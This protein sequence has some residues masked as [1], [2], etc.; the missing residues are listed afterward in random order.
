M[1][2]QVSKAQV[3]AV[4]LF[5]VVCVSVGEAL[6]SVGM[7]QVEKGHFTGLKFVLA[8]AANRTVIVGTLLM[9]V[10]FG[11][12]SLALSWADFSFVLPLT[13][14]SYLFGALLAQFALH[15]TVS[16][17]RWFGV[18]MITLGV[19]VVG[20][21]SATNLP[22]PDAASAPQVPVSAPSA[23]VPADAPSADSVPPR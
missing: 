12:Y 1:E 11:L 21:G 17:L 23:S 3:V 8:A 14:A 6:L 15:E 13:A 10:F 9:M 2:N 18:A 20:A 7:K 16:P 5:A 4:V 22:A 19:I